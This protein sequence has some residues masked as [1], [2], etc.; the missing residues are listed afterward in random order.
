MDDKQDKATGQGGFVGTATETKIIGGVRRE[1][2]LK[3]LGNATVYDLRPI[4]ERNK[5]TAKLLKALRSGFKRH[6]LPEGGAA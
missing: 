2:K 1:V 5:E 3:R 4:L 6:V